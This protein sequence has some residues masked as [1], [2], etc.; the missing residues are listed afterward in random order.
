[1]VIHAFVGPT[2]PGMEICHNN[3]IH[4]DNRLKNLRFDTHAANMEDLSYKLAKNAKTHCVHGHKFTPENT[5]YV[6]GRL[7]A[8]YCR[9]CKTLKS[10]RY[11]ARKLS[12]DPIGFRRHNADRQLARKGR[13]RQSVSKT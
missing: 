1:M 13:L 11:H 2:P 8:R 6:K 5:G 10:R 12:E 4:A 7:N 3:G 9:S